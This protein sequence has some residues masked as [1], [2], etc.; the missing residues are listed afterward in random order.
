MADAGQEDAETARTLVGDFWCIGGM[1]PNFDSADMQAFVNA[2]RALS[3]DTTDGTYM[4]KFEAAW[5]A[6]SGSALLTGI[7]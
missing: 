3:V 2:I 7:K 1:D 5:M 6:L 4:T